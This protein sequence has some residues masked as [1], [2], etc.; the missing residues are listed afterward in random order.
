[1]EGGRGMLRDQNIKGFQLSFKS[2]YGMCWWMVI[3]CCMLPLE[4]TDGMLIIIKVDYHLLSCDLNKHTFS[5]IGAHGH[6]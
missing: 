4:N 2:M 6:L 1:M 3:C 5:Y